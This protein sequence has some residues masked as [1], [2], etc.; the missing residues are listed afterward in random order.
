VL[1]G[2]ALGAGKSW[3]GALW[4]IL[5]ALINPGCTILVVAQSAGIHKQNLFPAVLNHLDSFAINQGYSLVQ[6]ARSGT[7]NLRV[8]IRNGAELLFVGQDW[9]LTNRG[10]QFAAILIDEMSKMWR[11]EELYQEGVGR[12]RDPRARF[13][14]IVVLMNL[15]HG[16]TGILRQFIQRTRAGDPAADLILS[17]TSENTTLPA[18]YVQSL[19]SIMSRSRYAAMVDG[20]V[21][22]CQASVWPEFSRRRHILRIDATKLRVKL[23]WAVSLDWGLQ[24]AALVALLCRVAAPD[25]TRAH[26]LPCDIFHPYH[27]YPTDRPTALA[28]ICVDELVDDALNTTERF[29]HGVGQLVDKWSQIQGQDPLIVAY[30]PAGG[31]R[32][33]RDVG[34]LCSD[35]DTRGWHYGPDEKDVW[36]GVELLRG[37][38]DP[39][40]GIPR[41]WVTEEL[42]GRPSS[43]ER[44]I[45]TSME[46]LPRAMWHGDY[47]SQIAPGTPYEHIT[48]D[49]RYL[50]RYVA[51]EAG[52][53]FLL[54]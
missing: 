46:Q 42:A 51:R 15:E 23:P 50:V 24:S 25:G 38:L 47:A 36:E 53:R 41:F 49:A 28:L 44:G 22:R 29:M 39:M 10:P 16:E 48:D 35:R 4:C 18:D 17:P 40:S 43:A 8:K 32:A 45:A 54:S 26:G 34:R 11:P 14:Q 7:G 37:W 9:L 3:I 6:Y 31:K 33:R 30:D 1:W 21:I 27:D 19:R 13:R 12:L 52:E 2:G 20:K 5:M